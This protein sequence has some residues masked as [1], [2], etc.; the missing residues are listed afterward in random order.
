MHFSF[1]ITILLL[2]LV[3]N[4]NA[5]IT[6]TCPQNMVNVPGAGP[7]NTPVQVFFDM[8]T[9]TTDCPQGG[10]TITQTS[11]QSSGDSFQPY[12]PNGPS[13]PIGIHTVEF[14]AV[15][16]CGNITFC[17]FSIT[18]EPWVATTTYTFP[19]NITVTAT[20]P[21]GANVFWLE[22]EVTT[23][24]PTPIN[25]TNLSIN[26]GGLFPIGTTTVTY[27]IF[28]QGN[29]IGGCITDEQQIFYF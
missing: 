28:R 6:L 15:D 20:S 2:F 10:L 7:G 18:V 19:E 14:Q 17:S 21:D 12:I 16:A 5:G 13:L 25:V 1:F 8:P 26:N 24:C 23:D 11:G 9:G 27:H 3:N 29:N 22:P 4:V